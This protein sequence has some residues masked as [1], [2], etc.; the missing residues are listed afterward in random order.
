MPL[1]QINAGHSGPELHG[2]SRPFAPLLDEALRGTG[3]IVVMLHGFKFAPG[4]VTACPHRHILSLDPPESCWKARSWPRELG[5][6]TG[7]PDEGLAIAFGW[8]ARGTIWQ[9]YRRAEAAGRA[10]AELVLT[11]R[12]RA[13][14]RPVHMLAH[15]LGARVVLSALPHLPAGS[16]GRAILLSGAEYGSRAAAALRSEAG[17]TAEFL[18]VTSRENDLFDFMLERV[19]APPERGDWTLGQ[20]MPQRPNT[21]T[22]QLDHP[23]TLEALAGAGFRIAPPSGRVC[24]WSSYLRPG[25]FPLY[26]ALLRRDGDFPLA[27][28]RAALPERPEPRWSRFLAVPEIRLPLPSRPKA[29]S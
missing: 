8:Q 9:A 7:R 2:S 6:G 12:R 16:L 3:P 29:P 17:A 28:L 22:L 14:H 5:F 1:V 13:P 15:S 4:H 21:L 26:R 11:L 25:V 24:H 18:N 23:E 20:R 10:L 27:R 19:I